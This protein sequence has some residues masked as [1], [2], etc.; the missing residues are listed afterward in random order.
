MDNAP[1]D[2]ELRCV[3]CTRSSGCAARHTDEKAEE[4][5]SSGPYLLLGAAI[6]LVMTVV[7]KWAL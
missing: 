5:I 7:L 2:A 4:E 3:Q 1:T 6:I